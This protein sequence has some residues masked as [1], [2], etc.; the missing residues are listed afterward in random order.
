MTQMTSFIEIHDSNDKVPVCFLELHDSND[1][2][3]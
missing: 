3:Y 2:L 1:K